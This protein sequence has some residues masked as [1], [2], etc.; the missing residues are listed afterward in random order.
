[1]R[2]ISS[3]SVLLFAFEYGNPLAQPFLDAAMRREPQNL[4][5]AAI[6]R[7]CSLCRIG[8]EARLAC[9]RATTR[10]S[11]HYDHSIRHP[12]HV[13]QDV[14]GEEHGAVRILQ[15]PHDRR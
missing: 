3:L 14:R 2:A 9:R 8:R 1:M 10:P 7:E 15:Q 12:F 11:V 5:W 6:R 13:R 4:R